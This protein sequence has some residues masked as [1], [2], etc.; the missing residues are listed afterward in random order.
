MDLS[1]IAEISLFSDSI[2]T[3]SIALQS[4]AIQLQ[5]P[6][7]AHRS[8][9]RHM[10]LSARDLQASAHTRNADP[11]QSHHKLTA[12]PAAGLHMICAGNTYILGRNEKVEAASL[13]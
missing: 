12:H 3:S 2:W 10:H 13:A 11:S 6:A 7:E 9:T 1:A 5:G 4:S 8:L